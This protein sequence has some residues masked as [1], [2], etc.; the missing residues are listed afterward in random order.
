M[1]R[2][3]DN[4]FVESLSQK[5]GPRFGPAQFAPNATP[6]VRP[7]RPRAN[8]GESVGD[9]LIQPFTDIMSEFSDQL[10]AGAQRTSPVVQSMWDKEKGWFSGEMRY[11]KLGKLVETDSGYDAYATPEGFKYFDK[12]TSVILRD[13]ETGGLSVYLRSPATDE[14]VLASAGRVLGG[15]FLAGPVAGIQAVGAKGPR[16][17]QAIAQAFRAAD[18]PAT[19]GAVFGR[20]TR[21]AQNFAK[22]FF[23]TAGPVS[24]RMEESIAATGTRIEELAARYGMATTPKG[25]GDALIRGGETFLSKFRNT[26]DRLYKAVDAK[27]PQATAVPMMATMKRLAGD[28]AAVTARGQRGIIAPFDDPA[29]TKQFAEPLVKDIATIIA[30]NGGKLSWNDARMLR[31]KIGQ[32]L[33]KP[34]IVSDIDRAQ[35]EA[36]YGALTED[37]GSVAKAAGAGLEW[38]RAGRYWMAG[39]KRID[40]ALKEIL[41]PDQH[42]EAAFRTLY[43]S[44]GE[45]GDIGKLLAIKRSLPADEWDEVAGVVLRQL[46]KPVASQAGLE[47]AF[48]PSSFLTRYLRDLS[49]EAK[50]AL[51]GGSAS[52]LRRSLDTLAKVAEA[53][54]GIERVANTSRTAGI[55]SV[56]A[57]AT[58]LIFDPLTTIASTVGAN[59]MARMLMHP[60]A[61]RWLV[62]ATSAAS[63]QQLG[64]RVTGLSQLARLDPALR[65]FASALA[66]L[67]RADETG[68][69]PAIPTKAKSGPR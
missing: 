3:G 33:D 36:L 62:G 65:E 66:P 7:F 47:E 10:L 6:E 38:D 37:L 57:L 21:L 44:A 11:Q 24:R 31:T 25:G 14:G 54:K 53:Q 52:P 18:V 13:P 59:L 56:G 58:G 17:A 23:P 28:P 9:K 2:F 1:A 63:K 19:P 39:R 22:D 49:S 68:D 46:G 34:T 50:D 30:Q 55:A 67:V 69:S 15:G 5:K 41:K 48:S 26:A 4:P 45:K 29:L 27:I 40:T 42:G 16:T 60:G 61:V 64:A 51:F 12:K 8:A 32:L 43:S 20:G 35:V